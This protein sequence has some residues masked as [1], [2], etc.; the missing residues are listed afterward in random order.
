MLIHVSGEKE[1]F[2]RGRRT[3]QLADAGE[4]T[5]EEKTISFE[6]PADLLQMLTAARL[7]VLRAVREKPRSITEI[8]ECLGR[9]RSAVKRDIA[10]LADAGLLVVESKPLPGHGR[11]KEVRTA[12]NSLR[13]EAVLA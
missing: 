10:L 13:L 3:A 11:K 12:A 4:L 7:T 6:D 1:F 2:E 8:A 5:A 9:D